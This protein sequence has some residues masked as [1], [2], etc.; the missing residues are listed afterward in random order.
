MKNNVIVFTLMILLCGCQKSVFSTLEGSEWQCSIAEGCVD[1]YYFLPDSNYVSYNCEAD[2]KS[3][4]KYF[5]QKDTLYIHESAYDLDS[6]LSQSDG[7]YGLGKSMYKIVLEY[8]KLKHV[9]KWSYIDKRNEW[10]KDD[11]SFDEN[12]LFERVK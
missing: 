6:T 11:F 1:C 10:V 7:Y 5:I 8:G 12:Y 9:G 3:Y 4:G 2:C